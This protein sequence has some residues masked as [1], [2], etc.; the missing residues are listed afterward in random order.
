MRLTFL[1]RLSLRDAAERLEINA[2]SAERAQKQAIAALGHQLV[3][4]G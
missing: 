3:G 4:V 2:L 1:E